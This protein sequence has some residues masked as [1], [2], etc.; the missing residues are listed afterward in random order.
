MIFLSDFSI[1]TI[2][3]LMSMAAVLTV[4]TVKSN[5]GND[6]CDFFF[7]VLTNM[8]LGSLVAVMISDTR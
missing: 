1:L 4:V 2:I 3:K 8:T 6:I 7:A 5:E